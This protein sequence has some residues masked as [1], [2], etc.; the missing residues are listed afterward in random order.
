VKRLAASIF[1]TALAI[2]A[3][4]Q[5]SSDFDPTPVVAASPLPSNYTTILDNPDVLVMHVHYGAHEF[6]AMHD[7]PAVA[8]MYLYLDDSGEVDIIHEGAGGTAHRPPTHAGAYRLAPGIAE[9]H[10]IQSNSDTPSDFLR[11]EFKNITFPKLPEAGKHFSAPESLTPGATIEFQND[12]L[13]I[14][15]VICDAAKPCE[16]PSPSERT[17]VVPLTPTAISRSGVEGPD[18]AM[19]QPRFLPASSDGAYSLRQGS[20]AL[21][22]SFSDAPAASTSACKF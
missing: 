9:R 16:V 5:K 14:T 12:A 6:V 15:R 10:S 3:Q 19:G 21:V 20:E 11:I 18:V 7:H 4:A 17:L 2:C 13:T 22:L 1:V 8:T